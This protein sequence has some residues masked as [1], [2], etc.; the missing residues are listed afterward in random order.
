[1]G[2]PRKGGNTDRLLGEF[3]RGFREGGGEAEKACVG[4]LGIAPCRALRDCERTGECAI[5]DGMQALV[6]RMRAADRIAIASPIFFYGLPAQL[7]AAVDRG[8]FL[9]AREH[10]LKIAP[11]DEKQAFV[12]LLGATKG[13]NLFRGSLL[14]LK[15]F[16]EPFGIRIAGKL[17]YRKVDRPGDIERNPAALAEA[18]RAGKNFAP[19]GERR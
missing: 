14:T 11:P 1:M 9:W 16:L 17:L 13:E 4:D 12:L 2:S 3:V 19:K 7:K 10:L 18:F 5:A 8:Q 15:Y 6:A